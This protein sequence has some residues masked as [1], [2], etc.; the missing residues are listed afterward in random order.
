MNSDEDEYSSIRAEFIFVLLK[1]NILSSLVSL[2]GY[3]NCK[4]YL[5]LLLMCFLL[6]LLAWGSLLFFPCCICD[7]SFTK[8]FFGHELVYDK[9]PLNFPFTKGL[10]YQRQSTHLNFCA[11]WTWL[12][13]IP[14]G[15]FHT[16]L[17]R[18]GI[19]FYIN[20]A[21]IILECWKSI[22]VLG[23]CQIAVDYLLLLLNRQEI[24][25][26]MWQIHWSENN[27]RHGFAIG[28]TQKE[29]IKL[30]MKTNNRK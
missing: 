16:D 27:L 18:N 26:W 28:R 21:A 25:N 15:R 23:H 30:Q 29:I 22:T 7:R 1:V 9:K 14:K 24:Q 2:W 11:L 6:T 20:V 3:N 17:L 4:L 12:E 8:P 10:P 5:M 19:Q 13:F